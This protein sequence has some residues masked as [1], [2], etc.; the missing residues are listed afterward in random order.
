MTQKKKLQIFI[1][2]TYTDLREER[3]AAV[4][5]VLTAG[6]IPAGMELFAAGD[7]SQMDVIK[8]WIDESDVYMLILGGRYG[9]IEQKTQKSYVHLEYEYALKKGKPL[10]AVVINENC[11]EKR[12]KKYGVSA[13]EKEYPD[14][15]KKFRELVCSKMVRFWTDSKDIKLSIMETMSD[16]SKRDELAGWQQG[17]Q[18][19]VLT[20]EDTRR[21]KISGSKLQNDAERQLREQKILSWRNTSIET[22][23]GKPNSLSNPRKSL[24]VSL[25]KR[26]E[27]PQNKNILHLAYSPDGRTLVS[28]GNDTC[29]RLWDVFFGREV[30]TFDGHILGVS[31]VAVNNDGRVLAAGDLHSVKIWSIP[32]S[33]CIQT[34]QISKE[35]LSLSVSK[36]TFN[37][38]LLAVAAN[39]VSLVNW[40]TGENLAEFGE[41]NDG[42]SDMA[43]SPN[44]ELLAYA[45]KQINI[46]NLDTRHLYKIASGESYATAL[47]FSPDS[48]FLAI[49][50][51]HSETKLSEIAIFD[52]NNRKEIRRF[53]S[54]SE[55]VVSCLAFNLSD[56]SILVSG[57]HDKKI[58]F[59][60]YYGRELAMIDDHDYPIGAIVFS[61]DD[62]TLASTGGDRV[63][64]I[65]TLETPAG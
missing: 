10:F 61:E 22:K 32:K 16:F 45:E 65:W 30:K 38:D 59:W 63:I 4:E 6:H 20:S 47:A 50:W 51:M 15:L 23:S 54:L 17:N 5:A 2:S 42:I 31:S 8:R 55:Q 1:S 56:G 18:L 34:L 33:K 19:E 28:A 44:G 64:R 43:F 58:R 9:S 7:K 25:S 41:Y 35:S 36:L 11:L 46:V 13:I 60:N 57:G 39:K 21:K 24:K 27:A 52:L 29:V 26:L 49:C 3:Q 53:E 14:K 62:I 12:F 37:L 48:N 40:K